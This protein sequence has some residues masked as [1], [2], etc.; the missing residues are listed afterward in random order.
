MVIWLEQGLI[1]MKAGQT[2]KMVVIPSKWYG[3]QYDPLH[4]QK[5]SKLLFDKIIDSIW[6][7]T[8]FI[9]FAGVTGVVKGIEKDEKGNEIVLRDIN[10]RETRDNLMYEVTLLSKK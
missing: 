4:L 6:E 7:K 5:I 2:K 3:D 8:R 10:P 1:G 9:S